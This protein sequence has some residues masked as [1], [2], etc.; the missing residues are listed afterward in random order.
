MPF[1]RGNTEGKKRGRNKKTIDQEVQRELF[2]KM[3]DAKWGDIIGAHIDSS[4][5]PGKEG[6]DPRRYII[7]QRVGKPTEHIKLDAEIDITMDF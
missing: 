5:I 3:V 1:K 6:N 4:L 2:N 7:N